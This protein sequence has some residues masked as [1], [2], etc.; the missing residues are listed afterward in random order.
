M[1]KTPTSRRRQ[2]RNQKGGVFLV[3]TAAES[4][5]SSVCHYER[6]ARRGEDLDEIS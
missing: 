6:R 4:V 5:Q 2:V 3:E 1:L